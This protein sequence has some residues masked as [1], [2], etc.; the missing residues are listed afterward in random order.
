MVFYGHLSIL[1]YAYLKWRVGGPCGGM[2]GSPFRESGGESRCTCC[3]IVV[4][5]APTELCQL[6]WAMD[7]TTWAGDVP[8]ARLDERH[9]GKSSRHNFPGTEYEQ[10]IY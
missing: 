4:D 6:P 10:I 8:P 9:G 3:T 1:I 7:G 2:A 5:D